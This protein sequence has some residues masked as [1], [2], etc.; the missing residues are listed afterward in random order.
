MLSFT[1]SKCGDEIFGE[2]VGDETKI[3]PC[4]G[5]LSDMFEKEAPPIMFQQLFDV[6]CIICGCH[7]SCR[8]DQKEGTIYVG[9]CTC[10]KEGVDE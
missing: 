5:C 1:C 2:K 8:I 10:A 7:V 4:F 6:K 9:I 3:Y